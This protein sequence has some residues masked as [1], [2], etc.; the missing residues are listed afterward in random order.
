MTKPLLT[1]ALLISA[2]PALAQSIDLTVLPAVTVTTPTPY[3]YSASNGPK[4]NILDNNPATAWNGGAYSDWVQ[5]D[6]GT[7]YVFDH[8]ELYGNPGYVNNYQLLS[9][10]DGQAWTLIASGSYHNEPALA[11]TVKFGAVHD[12][13]VGSPLGRYLRYQQTSGTQWAYL[14]ELEITGHL[15]ANHVSAVPL[16]PSAALMLSGLGLLGY[17]V[18]RKK[19]T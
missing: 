8:I 18:R 3:Y 17:V 5:V 2:T 11:G 13:V 6:F 15:P 9:S 10:V 16:P 14:S 4:D 1:A 12:Y 7:A 19:R